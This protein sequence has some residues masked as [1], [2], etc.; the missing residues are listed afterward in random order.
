MK[1]H[2][3]GHPPL[4]DVLAWAWLLRVLGDK[5]CSFLQVIEGPP[6]PSAAPGQPGWCRP[7]CWR[8]GA[9]SRSHPSG[10]GRSGR[11]STSGG[12]FLLL[13]QLFVP[14]ETDGAGCRSCRPCCRSSRTGAPT[15][16]R[17]SQVGRAIALSKAQLW[18]CRERVAGAAPH[19]R[20]VLGLTPWREFA[21][22]SRRWP[23]RAW[24][25][26]MPVA[27]WNPW[28]PAFRTSPGRW[29]TAH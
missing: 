7:C 14:A 10:S 19:H 20:S 26:L 5:Q 1:F 24:L 9:R 8:P 4:R 6:R 25:T 16:R 21:P 23:L 29:S 15:S 3:D 12:K 28:R 2:A 13:Q 27:A 17:S 18:P 11:P 22:A